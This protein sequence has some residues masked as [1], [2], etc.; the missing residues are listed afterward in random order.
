MGPKS[1]PSLVRGHRCQEHVAPSSF[2]LLILRHTRLQYL[3]PLK[4]TL[5]ETRDFILDVSR[6][7]KGD[8]EWGR[9]GSDNTQPE[10][11]GEKFGKKFARSFSVFEE[12]E[13]NIFFPGWTK[14]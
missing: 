10:G 4:K 14:P 8:L 1:F 11:S 13:S 12:N 5:N 2:R 3:K 9:A 7:L 6:S